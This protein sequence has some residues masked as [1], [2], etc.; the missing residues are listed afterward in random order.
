MKELRDLTKA[1]SRVFVAIA[2][3]VELN[4]DSVERVSL[5]ED[6][7]E[8]SEALKKGFENLKGVFTDKELEA[9]K[10]TVTNRFKKVFGSSDQQ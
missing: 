10:T 9:I 1:T 6:F 7:E 3:R 8:S 2:D 4:N 5:F